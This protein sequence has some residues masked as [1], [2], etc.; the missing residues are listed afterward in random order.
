MSNSSLAEIKQNIIN[1]ESTNLCWKDSPP[2]QRLLNAICSI[3]AEEYIIIAKQ[4]PD[5]FTEIASR[6]S[7]A[8][9]NEM[10]LKE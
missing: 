5:V 1:K 2:T 3:L 7:G 4:N 10:E 6:P 9:N 8:H